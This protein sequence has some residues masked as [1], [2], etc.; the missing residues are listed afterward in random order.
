MFG[1]E[2][3]FQ[4]FDDNGGDEQLFVTDGTAGGTSELI[5]SDGGGSGLQPTQLTVLSS[6][7]LFAGVDFTNAHGLWATNGAA[8]RNIGDSVHQRPGRRP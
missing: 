6:E 1:S 4:G 7:V 2:V 5:V 3:L 8:R